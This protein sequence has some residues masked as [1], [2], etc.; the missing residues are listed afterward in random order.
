MRVDVQTN[1]R[2]LS[3]IR[4][5]EACI[6]I[7]RFET[8]DTKGIGRAGT[9]IE[10]RDLLLNEKEQERT[11]LSLS[12]RALLPWKSSFQHYIPN[13][14]R[15]RECVSEYPK[16][17]ETTGVY[18]FY[19]PSWTITAMK[20]TFC[21]IV[22]GLRNSDNWRISWTRVRFLSTKFGRSVKDQ[23]Q[24]E[25]LIKVRAYPSQNTFRG[26]NKR[27]PG[28]SVSKHK[29]EED[30]SV[31]SWVFRYCWTASR[32]V[33]KKHSTNGERKTSEDTNNWS[34]KPGETG[35]MSAKQRQR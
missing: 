29:L 12:L 32:A 21:S 2:I 25:F 33:G 31:G 10:S 6:F 24:E 20:V 22:G 11:F 8:R 9:K 16:N 28:E 26:E 5:K 3:S 30:K 27:H 14:L 17:S 4:K 1:G 15:S 13:G 7:H 35:K 23:K 18:T 34:W 19:A